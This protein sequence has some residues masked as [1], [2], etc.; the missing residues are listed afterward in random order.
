ML[1]IKVKMAFGRK[2][3]T[4]A[5]VGQLSLI[6]LAGRRGVEAA[7]AGVDGTSN[8]DAYTESIASGWL[9]SS[10]GERHEPANVLPVSA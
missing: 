4:Y 5:L 9:G 10:R 7:G 1:A 2:G 8:G 3:R 6:R